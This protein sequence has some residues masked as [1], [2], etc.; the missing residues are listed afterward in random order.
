[1]RKNL[2]QPS[3]AT[4]LSA[5][6]KSAPSIHEALQT[7]L[8]RHPSVAGDPSIFW[9]S[10]ST[11]PH[12][13]LG[14]DTKLSRHLTTSSTTNVDELACSTAVPRARHRST[15]ST[16]AHTKA[17]ASVETDLRALGIEV[18]CL[19]QTFHRGPR[20]T[21]LAHW[22]VRDFTLLPCC[23]KEPACRQS[24]NVSILN[25]FSPFD[26]TMDEG[27]PT[28]PSPRRTPC[29]QNQCRSARQAFLQLV[30]GAAPQRLAQAHNWVPGVFASSSD[31]SCTIVPLS[32]PSQLQGSLS[33]GREEPRAA[34]TLK[35]LGYMS[36]AADN[37]PSSK[38]CPAHPDKT[39][40]R[41]ETGD[42]SIFW[43]SYAGLSS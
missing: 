23:S 42:P 1:V 2:A 38:R 19:R 26:T 15:P 25:T 28:H 20:W 33:H 35:R 17:A 12:E 8:E 34:P 10:Y 6:A 27:C 18:A 5:L 40:L 4:H 29:R 43:T 37:S 36:R 32:S 22:A 13:S 3:I 16:C 41:N 9:T 11:E 39:L 24:H 7:N 21:S 14:C 31:H 30:Q